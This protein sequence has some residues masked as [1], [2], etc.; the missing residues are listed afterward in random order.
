[1]P[2]MLDVPSSRVHRHATMPRLTN[3]HILTIRTELRFVWDSAPT[4]IYPL[5]ALE[6][7]ALHGCFRFTENLSTA[8]MVENGVEIM[9]EQPSLPQR[10]GRAVSQ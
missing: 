9:K 7:W 6:Q 10:A 3:Q 4:S 1:M 2:F 5:S 8:Q